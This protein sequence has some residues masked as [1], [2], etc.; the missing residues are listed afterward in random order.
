ML[1]KL[2]IKIVEGKAETEFSIHQMRHREKKIEIEI[3]DTT[4]L[5]SYI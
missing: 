4:M 1:G 3:E 2:G 5:A